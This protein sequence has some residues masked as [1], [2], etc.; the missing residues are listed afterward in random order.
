[1]NKQ[2][3]THIKD[4]SG[5]IPLKMQVRLLRKEVSELNEWR[6]DRVD[7][8]A[9]KEQRIIDL[10]LTLRAEGTG[11][12][13]YNFL[14]TKLMREIMRRKRCMDYRDIV[15]FAHFKTDEEAYRLM[16]RTEKNYPQYVEI[17]KI[18][19]GRTTKKVICR[20]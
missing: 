18:K 20:L 17:R 13:D 10:E 6:K 4:E 2:E 9:R 5:D 16:N 15:G 8:D 11:R 3:D 19:K 1:M 14:S 12:R 7:E